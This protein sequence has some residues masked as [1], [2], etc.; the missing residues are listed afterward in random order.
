MVRLAIWGVG[1]G[2]EALRSRRRGKPGGAGG[3]QAGAGLGDKC[4]H[5]RQIGQSKEWWGVVM[6]DGEGTGGC[7]PA[8]RATEAT[9][10]T[11]ATRRRC[12]AKVS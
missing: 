3:P 7:G 9:A 6:G 5:R 4:G 1:G 12:R 11:I 8:A 10:E 2:A